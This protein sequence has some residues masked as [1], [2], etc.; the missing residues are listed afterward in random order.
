MD[1]IE[2]KTLKGEELK[3]AFDMSRYAFNA[4]PKEDKEI[5]ARIDTFQD[6]YVTALFEN[7]KPMAT[8]TTLPM[9]QNV[10]GK[11]F[12]MAGIAMVATEPEGRNKGYAKKLMLEHFKEMKK[13]EYVFSTLYPFKEL[14]YS[15]L[16]YTTFPQIKEAIFNPASLEPLLKYQVKG[17][18][19]K[20][21]I[22]GGIKNYKNFM[23]Y[24]QPLIHGF[25]LKPDKYFERM[26]ERNTLWL[27]I[28]KVDNEIVGVMIYK[29]TGYFEKLQI[30]DFY[31][32]DANAKYLLLQYLAKHR[33]QVKEVFLP[34]IANE[35]IEC[36]IE[37]LSPKIRT[38]E[39]V[40][41]AMGRVMIVEELSG[42][43]VENGHFKARI[44]DPYCDWNNGVFSFQSL[45]GLLLVEKGDGQPDCEMT[46][47]GL[48][49]IIY[50]GHEIEDLKIKG[51]I[52]GNS[53]IIKT[54][55]TM[56]P[57]LYPHLHEDF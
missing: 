37:D 30:K 48:S 39:W 34:L 56:F 5:E 21:E 35:N 52:S 31:Y 27:A 29:I 44:S 24:I 23:E 53:T 46:I 33:D 43:K 11:I 10:R 13:T 28:A 49:A 6:N 45:N 40:A 16:G 4:S 17:S 15:K 54:I 9:T 14:F 47:N 18:V 38:R 55:E 36:W 26:K 57:P 20:I 19:E 32:L 51:Q 50:G 42:M 1:K 3:I 12:P 25:G 8:V 7:E 2:I 41:S 22:K